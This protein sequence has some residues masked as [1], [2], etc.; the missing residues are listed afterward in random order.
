MRAF[1]AAVIAV[2]C[3]IAAFAAGRVSAQQP[4]AAPQPKK[5]IAPPPKREAAPRAKLV[6]P[7]PPPAA[8]AKAPGQLH[9]GPEQTLYLIRSAL[10]TLND[11]N[12]SG[13]Y[14][15]LRD[16]AA[17][18][19]RDKHSTADLAQVFADLRQRRFDLAAAGIYAPQL[20]QAPSVD[21]NGLLR[22]TGA[23]PTRPL[24]I[25]FDLL[26][27]I[28]DNE[29]RVFGIAVSTPEA[30]PAAAVPSPASPATSPPV[31]QP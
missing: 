14:S 5:E 13:N 30:P 11:A 12:R 10:L 24:L 6:E 4:G 9:I 22:L 18:G 27:Q 17:P 1:R 31:K 26:F 2:V 21:A 19:F 25:Q 28:V 3:V 15:V 29:W 16:L 20:T 23:Y 7:A 8:P